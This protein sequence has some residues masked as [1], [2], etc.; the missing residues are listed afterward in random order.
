MIQIQHHIIQPIQH[1][2]A[3]VLIEGFQPLDIPLQPSHDHRP[4]RP[5]YKHP[6]LPLQ[7][8]QF[9]IENVVVPVCLVQSARRAG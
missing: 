5:D 1:D 7:L 9:S 8:L 2:P 6:S 4:V 3:P